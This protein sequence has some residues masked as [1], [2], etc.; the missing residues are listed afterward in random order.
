MM[1]GCGGHSLNQIEGETASQKQIQFSSDAAP[2]GSQGP[3]EANNLCDLPTVSCTVVEKTKFVDHC[4]RQDN[5]VDLIPI[6]LRGG[7]VFSVIMREASACEDT[8][9]RSH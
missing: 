1:N 5:A 7:F 4:K 8:C 6:A 2:E 3:H 9:I